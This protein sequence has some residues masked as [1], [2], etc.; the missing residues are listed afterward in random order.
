MS[1]PPTLGRLFLVP[2]PLG[3]ESDPKSVLPAATIEAVAALRHFVAE[4]ARPAPRFLA[5][6]PPAVPNPPV[7]FVEPNE[8]TPPEALSSLPL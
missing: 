7:Q 4:N 6:L 2:M 8:H 3:S 5:R 1:Q